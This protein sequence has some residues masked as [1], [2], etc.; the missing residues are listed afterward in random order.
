MLLG[1]LENCPRAI[2]RLSYL[3][4]AIKGYVLF[5]VFCD[6][7]NRKVKHTLKIRTRGFMNDSRWGL[8]CHALK[9][10]CIILHHIVGVKTWK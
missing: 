4:L 8:P 1:S 5:V 9:L 10:V 3:L 6:P 2:T 7:G